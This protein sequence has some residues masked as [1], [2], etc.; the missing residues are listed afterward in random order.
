MGVAVASI[1][2]SFKI[3]RMSMYA[4]K[5]I[6]FEAFYN[7]DVQKAPFNTRTYRSLY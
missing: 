3:Q 5:R 4:A 7:S 2:D 6:I 1:E